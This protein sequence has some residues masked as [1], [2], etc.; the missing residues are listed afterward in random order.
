VLTESNPAA[1]LSPSSEGSTTSD[2]SSLRYMPGLDVMRGLAI[3]MVLVYHGLTPHV[4]AFA[5]SPILMHLQATLQYGARGVHLFFILSGFLITGILID[6]RD[7]PAYYRN[8][9]I[10]RILRIVPAYFLMLGVLWFTHSI[11]GRYLAVCL[12][13]FCNM[14]AIFGARPQYGP[15]W[16]LSVE[17]QFYLTWPLVVRNV[18]IRALTLLSW[19]LI[20][21]TPFLRFAITYA[22]RGFDDVFTKTWVLTDFFAAGSLLAIAVRTPGC[23]A[24]LSRLVGPLLAGGLVLLIALQMLPTRQSGLLHRFT[25]AFVLEPWLVFF[26]GLVLLAYLRPQMTR[27]FAMRPL[28]FL[29]NISYGLYLCHQF[30]FYRV[31]EHWHLT[32]TTVHGRFGQLILRFATESALAILVAWISRRTFE[33]FFLRRKPKRA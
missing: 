12:F 23:R 18:S 10:R 4:E 5:G 2:A 17:E 14:S 33:E 8:F 22:P 3:S 27:H 24:R 16:S 9:Y 19:F 26:S 28:L 11:S 15:F 29:A 1:V 13:Y 25:L 30:L 21:G 31:E 20:L 6:S 32:S 7:D